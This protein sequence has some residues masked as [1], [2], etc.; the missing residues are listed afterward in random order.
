VQRWRGFEAVPAGWGPCVTTIGV[1]DG[2][3][4]GHQI[5]LGN[6]MALARESGMPSVVVTFDPHPLAVLRGV[7]PKMLTNLTYKASLLEGLGLDALCV[8]PFT[9]PFS[10]LTPEQFVHH[11]LV[12]NLHAGA[13][14]VGANFRFGHHA[15]G[16]VDL[17]V[18]LGRQHGFAV[19]P[20]EL[21]GDHDNTWSS[22]YIRSRVDVAS[23]SHRRHRGPG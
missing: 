5:T 20:V 7:A 22:T 13:V 21:A 19:H 23:A 15:E 2:V 14:V 16:D 10:R 6:V 9:K 18:S 4:R 8:V 12:E 11:M 17:L 3:H 1:Y